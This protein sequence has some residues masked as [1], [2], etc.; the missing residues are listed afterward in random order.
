MAEKNETEVVK[1][2]DKKDEIIKYVVPEEFRSTV[3]LLEVKKINKKMYGFYADPI[4]I[5]K[6]DMLL[7]RKGFKRN[8]SEVIASLI[9]NFTNFMNNNNK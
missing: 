2:K 3:D 7:K 1:T 5:H 6:F 4:V 9:E 8:R